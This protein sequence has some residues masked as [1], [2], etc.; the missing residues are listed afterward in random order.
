MTDAAKIKLLI[1]KGEGLNIEFKKSH[2]ALSRSVF[3]T[4]C[5]FLNRKG[6][7][8]LLGVKDNGTIE[9]IQEE[10][11]PAQLKVLADD[12]NNPQLISPTFYLSSEVV[13]VDGKKIICI[14]VPESSQV[15][16]YLGVYYD[17][18]HEGDYKLNNQ[19]LIM[20]LFVRKYDGFTENKV[21]PN[22]QMEHF[23]P[24]CFNKVRNLVKV[25]RP[26][27]PWLNMSNEELLRSAKMYLTDIHTNQSGYTLAAALTFGTEAT[28]RSVCG[29][30]KTDAL[31]R[32]DNV[33]R[34][35]DR[36]VITCNLIEAY[37][38]LMAFIRKHTP[39]RF[40]LE[41]NQRR[42]IR[43][44]IFRE[45]VANLLVHREF[46]IPYP[47]RLTIYKETVVSE[48]WTIPNTMGLITPEN[49]V[50]H[51]KNPTI[52]DFFR[53]LGWVEDLGSGIRNMFY[54][55]PIYVKGAMPI[56]EEGDVFK[57]TVRHTEEE[58]D[59]T[60]N[61]EKISQIKHADEVL[62]LIQE[63]P[64]I[65]AI[66]IGNKLSLSENHIR[67]ILA[68]L[69]EFKIIERKGSDKD[70]EWMIGMIG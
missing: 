37:S 56:M 50:P 55:C 12:M 20:S 62:A 45:M 59:D 35:D 49:V 64:K 28:I 34:Y 18:N 8:I 16:T 5:A 41:G 52:S 26:D 9:G 65:T 14:Y 60:I 30:Y 63:T 29:H 15:H 21:F 24:E 10:T 61:L 27:H 17:R 58:V 6:G 13:E 57:L 47:S 51:P 11:L 44:L 53:Q 22:L 46:S 68:R 33:D 19:H 36:D 38:R 7:H 54:Y 43:E 48:N 2:T 67:K 69:V 42:S 31:C 25:E 32:K 70:G 23:E 3:E 1:A 40:Y 39:D 4:I 66:S